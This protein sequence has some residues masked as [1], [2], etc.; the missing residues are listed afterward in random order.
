MSSSRR[1]LS[2]SVA[3][4]LSFAATAAFA[5]PSAPMLEMA[6][7]AVCAATDSSEAL[8][9]EPSPEESAG[10]I[11]LAVRCAS[12]DDCWDACPNAQSV[13]CVRNGCTYQL[14]GGGGGGGGGPTC[15]GRRCSEDSE[16]VCG[17]RQGYCNS[18]ACVW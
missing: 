5:E 12:E 3:V 10:L 6:Q 9:S 18:N 7:Q 14:P 15:P 4:L 16:C 8:T 13:T 11:C 17:T 1:S 2:W